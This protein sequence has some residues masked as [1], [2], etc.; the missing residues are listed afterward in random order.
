MIVTVERVM[1]VGK[2]KE[3][4]NHKKVDGRKIIGGK[5]IN[6]RGEKIMV[7]WTCGGM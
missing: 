5:K 3:Q 2:V 1:N 4:V 6:R 7:K